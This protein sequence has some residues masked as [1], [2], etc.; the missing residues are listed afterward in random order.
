MPLSP[1]SVL[2]LK[3]NGGV[4]VHRFHEDAQFSIIQITMHRPTEAAQ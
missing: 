3:V 1:H 2:F 4:T